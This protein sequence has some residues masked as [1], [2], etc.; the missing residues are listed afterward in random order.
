MGTTI[1]LL[2]ILFLFG[3]GI[4][5]YTQS[6]TQIPINVILYAR[7]DGVTDNTAGVQKALTQAAT[8]GRDLYFPKG[9]WV[10]NSYSSGNSV[11]LLPS[12]GTTQIPIRIYGDN[13]ATINSS[14]K[15]GHLITTN[16]GYY[17]NITI[18]NIKFVSTHDTSNSTTAINC[19]NIVNTNS[20]RPTRN[21]S[22]K[23]CTFVGWNGAM[24]LK[25]VSNVSVLNNYFSSP[26]GHDN[27][28]T[29]TA[30]AS[31]IFM[32]DDSLGDMNRN[33]KIIGNTFIAYDTTVAITSF[34]TKAPMDNA[35][36]GHCSNCEISHNTMIGFGTEAI[37]LQPLIAV[38]DSGSVLIAENTI[39]CQV[40]PGSLIIG[41]S[42]KLTGNDGI[43]VEAQNTKIND[44]ILTGVTTGILQ[45]AT[46]SWNYSFKGWQINNNKIYFTKDTNM[47]ISAGIQMQ[48]FS[49]SV[50]SKYASISGNF[51]I[52]DSSTLKQSTNMLVMNFMDTSE[53]S[54]NSII[55]SRLTKNGFGVRAYS[56]LADTGIVISG[57]VSLYADTLL[58]N[59]S[60]VVNGIYLSE[61]GEQHTGAI[62]QS[63]VKV[64]AT[65][66]TI[67]PTDY[68]VIGT[69]TTSTW[70]FP[71]A[72]VNRML[73][74]VNQGSGTITL[75]TAVTTAN[76]LTSTTLLAGIT[77]QVQYDGTVWRKIN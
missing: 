34:V 71:T 56:F 62:S 44:N 41:T 50:K 8:L 29:T 63:V 61:T 11:L 42:N 45:Y 21:I 64:S 68:T 40:P 77:Y 9:Q 35:V 24:T 37:G 22:I 17:V 54:N 3:L 6:N 67:L 28:T 36:Y 38:V 39:N 57:G 49:S 48:G 53:L 43:R 32:V 13:G 73:N 26:K 5:G 69:G 75:G 55:C 23:N 15:T 65:T 2:I 14:L 76:G 7:P 46:S 58:V 12:L 74:L 72:V 25:G 19:L 18:E 20:A 60:S 27:A 52:I 47:T 10:L 51:L 30:P 16:G 31:Y 59:S 66:Y 4:K 1:R 33:I 70:T